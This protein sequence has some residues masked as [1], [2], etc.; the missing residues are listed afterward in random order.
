MRPVKSSTKKFLSLLIKFF[1]VQKWRETMI[2][3]DDAKPSKALV[4]ELLTK[5]KTR[6]VRGTTDPFCRPA[7]NL[8]QIRFTVRLF[9]WLEGFKL[10]VT[11]CSTRKLKWSWK[12]WTFCNKIL[13][14]HL[15]AT[16]LQAAGCSASAALFAQTRHLCSPSAR[17]EHD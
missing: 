9:T 17:P 16:V 4:T 14:T 13:V 5:V 15:R 1:L 12:I 8:S 3:L 7:K 2:S 10:C 11:K 6:I